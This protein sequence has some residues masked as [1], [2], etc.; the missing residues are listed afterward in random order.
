MK[1]LILLFFAMLGA[2]STRTKHDHLA[3]DTTLIIREVLTNRSVD[4]VL[5]PIF[6]TKSILV[7]KAK[8]LKASYFYGIDKRVSFIDEND[9]RLLD[10]SFVRKNT[11]IARIIEPK[12]TGDSITVFLVVRPIGFGAELLFAKKDT[13]WINK[14]CIFHKF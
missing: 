9:P 12:R 6:D 14:D 13:N 2:C 7:I 10:T 1:Y 3:I 5:S 8:W 4:S 11:F